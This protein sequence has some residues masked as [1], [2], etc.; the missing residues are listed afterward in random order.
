L[1][2]THQLLVCTDDVNKLGVNI[3]TTKKNKG[4]LLEASREVGLEV[5]TEELYTWLHLATLVKIIIY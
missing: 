2:E 5:S 4:S 1:N 3:N